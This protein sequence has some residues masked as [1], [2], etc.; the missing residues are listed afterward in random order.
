VKHAP[1]VVISS[2]A[3]LAL[4]CSHRSPPPAFGLSGDFD[5]FPNI[6]IEPPPYSLPDFHVSEGDLILLEADEFIPPGADIVLGQTEVAKRQAMPRAKYPS[7]ET[8]IAPNE[9]AAIWTRS[10][11]YGA[12]MWHTVMLKEK[13]DERAYA[14]FRTRAS[15]D[16][17]WSTQSTLFA[18]SVSVRANRSEVVVIDLRGNKN[19]ID[20]R[21]E[22]ERYLPGM[23][24]GARL[25]ETAYGWTPEGDLIVRGLGQEFDPPHDRFGY[26]VV[27]HI[28]DASEKP[29]VRFVRGFIKRAARNE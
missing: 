25:F 14:V 2:L 13:P 3:V 10:E 21:E 23:H 19:R 17:V 9:Q 15:F 6:K 18:M 26:E 1:I 22:V 20:V 4:G 8:F 16:V 29:D 11:K 24:M 7:T 27:I 28:Q 12:N 5:F